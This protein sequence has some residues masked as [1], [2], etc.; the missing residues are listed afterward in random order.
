MRNNSYLGNYEDAKESFSLFKN[1]FDNTP[2]NNSS[3]FILNDSNFDMSLNSNIPYEE[4][5]I[6]NNN[7][8]QFPLF[9]LSFVNNEI[10][11]MLEDNNSVKT[12]DI[13]IIIQDNNSTLLN[14]DSKQYKD[15]NLKT[16]KYIKQ[17]VFKILKDNNTN[18]GRIKKNSK[19]IG[20]HNKFSQDNIIR[21]IKGRFQEK[22]R[23]YI[24]NEYKNFLRNNE[25]T[26]KV[27]NLLQRINPKVS[28][29]IQRDENLK[30]LN[31]K[32][33]EVFS[34]NVSEKCS[35]YEFDYNKKQIEKL[36]K[37]NKATNVINI[38][39]KSVKYMFDAFIQNLNIP[40]FNTLNDDINELEAKMKK[41]NEDDIKKC[42]YKYRTTAQNLESIFIHKNSRNNK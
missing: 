37:E 23:I 19:Y 2:N 22:C 28:R 31:S 6:F 33:Y 7:I 42:L 32:L 8:E 24:N 26:T 15:I 21:K 27:N 5:N 35:L 9:N 10:P 41:E 40:G 13:K 34:E 17:R 29:K 11:L 25:H 14:S 18:K 3:Y 12:K 39:N 20:I 36:Y 4:N 38:L 30:W 16:F 1:I